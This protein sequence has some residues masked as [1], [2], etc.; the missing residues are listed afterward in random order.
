MI[1]INILWKNYRNCL[2]LIYYYICS[3]FLTS[4]CSWQ[5]AQHGQKQWIRQSPQKLPGIRYLSLIF[6]LFIA[7]P[8]QQQNKG[9]QHALLQ[10]SR[11][12]FWTMHPWNTG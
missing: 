8:I 2:M 3:L 4:L 9:K 6:L 1:F 5:I 10:D 7:L 12:T 11:V